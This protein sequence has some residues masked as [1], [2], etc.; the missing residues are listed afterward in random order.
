M[1]VRLASFQTT[2]R[3]FHAHEEPHPYYIDDCLY[4]FLKLSADSPVLQASHLRWACS[5]PENPAVRDMGPLGEEKAKAFFASD[6][7]FATGICPRY[8]RSRR[9]SPQLPKFHSAFRKV[10]V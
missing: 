6:S 8:T 4:G 7:G 9:E 10:T 2:P 5:G 1:T 3:L